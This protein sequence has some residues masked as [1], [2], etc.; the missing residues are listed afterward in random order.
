MH[1]VRILTASKTQ[2]K[3]IMESECSACLSA[4]FVAKEMVRY[5]R[6]KDKTGNFPVPVGGEVIMII[7]ILA[8]YNG[9]FRLCL[10][11]TDTIAQSKRQAASAMACWMTLSSE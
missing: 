10:N 2:S 11:F 9:A 5:Q 3:Q 7:H 1:N 4:C 8:G 6:Y